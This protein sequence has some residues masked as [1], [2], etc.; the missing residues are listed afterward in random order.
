MTGVRRV[1]FRSKTSWYKYVGDNGMIFGI[2]EFGK[3]APYKKIFEYFGLSTKNITRK[4]KN[5][6]RT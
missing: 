2:D 6:Y 4:I 1:L 5:N 3:S